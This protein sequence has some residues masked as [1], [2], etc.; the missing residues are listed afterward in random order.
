MSDNN[1]YISKLVML[2]TPKISA[3]L[4]VI[5]VTNG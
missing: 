1:E 5:T 2:A 3:K 4:I